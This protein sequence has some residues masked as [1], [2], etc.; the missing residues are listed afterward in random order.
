MRSFV[1]IFTAWLL[2]AALDAVAAQSEEMPTGPPPTETSGGDSE[3]D[4]E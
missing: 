3:P 4:C 1:L 2:S